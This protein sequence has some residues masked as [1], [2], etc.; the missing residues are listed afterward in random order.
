VIVKNLGTGTRVVLKSHYGYEVIHHIRTIA[1]EDSTAITI[2]KSRDQYCSVLPVSISYQ[3]HIPSSEAVHVLLEWS[4][5]LLSLSSDWPSADHGE[6]PLPGGSHLKHS[7]PGR[8]DQLPA[9]R[10]TRDI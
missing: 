5:S 9:Q 2:Y 8:P 3:E 1:A 4:D 7:S 10:G 6:G